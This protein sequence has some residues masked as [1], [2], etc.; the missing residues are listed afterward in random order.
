M[1]EL[2]DKFRKL[3]DGKKTFLVSGAA[4]L[5]LAVAWAAGTVE[6]WPALQ[7][8]WGLVLVMCGRSAMKKREPNKPEMV[9]YD[10]E[11]SPA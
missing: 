8:A 9:E 4:L 11:G 10:E 7:T 2:V 3:V 6:N 5:S 1:F